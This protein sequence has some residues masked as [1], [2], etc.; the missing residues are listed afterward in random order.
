MTDRRTFRAAVLTIVGQPLEIHNLYFPDLTSG[1]VLVQNLLSGVCRSQLMEVQGERGDDK[2][3]PHLLGHEGYGI[4]REV[5]GDVKKVMP[6]DFVIASWIKGAGIDAKPPKYQ[7]TTNIEVHSGLVTTFSEYSVISE[8]RVFIAPQGFKEELMPLFGC[9]FL[10]GAGMVLNFLREA[11]ES[12]V[13]VYGFGGIGMSAALVLRGMNPRELFIIEKSPEKRALAISLGYLNVI[14]PDD[15][16]LKNL[17]F[18]YCFET[19]GSVGSIQAAWNLL[20]SNGTLIFASH[21]PNGQDISLDP[22]DL[23]KGKRIFGTWGG[24]VRPDEDIPRIASLLS[25]CGLNLEALVGKLFSLS[26]VNS[27]LSYL[28]SGSP[29]RPILDFRRS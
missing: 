16:S 4:V 19:A 28:E 10:T 3:L 17:K 23:I 8:S 5:A 21:P 13:A 14:P 2:W 15:D 25:D 20:K 26:D 29:G 9:A 18:D 6:G 24:N 1:Q 7:S 22:H 27:A 11:S 12:H